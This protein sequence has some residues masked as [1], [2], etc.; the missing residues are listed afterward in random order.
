MEDTLKIA[1]GV[2]I[3]ALAAAFTWEGIQ[4]IRVE[5]ALKKATDQIREANAQ[6]QAKS[7]AQQ[8][9]ETAE[10][11]QQRQER[12]DAQQNAVEAER[13]GQVREKDKAEAFKQFYQPSP[14]CIADPNQTTCANAFIKAKTVFNSQYQPKR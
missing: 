13:L 9:K 2:F 6:A 10:L 1:V 11:N 7:R 12:E 3:G 14:T 8:A 4:T 5:I